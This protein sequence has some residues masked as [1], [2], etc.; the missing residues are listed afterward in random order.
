MTQFSPEQESRLAE[1][2]TK[3]PS[4][5]TLIPLEDV[6]ETIGQSS[7]LATQKEKLSR[8]L[9]NLAEEAPPPYE[10]KI[11]EVV[12]VAVEALHPDITFDQLS[13]SEQ[14]R[15][16]DDINNRIGITI[17]IKSI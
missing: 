11:Q 17:D 1:T 14:R 5:E 13:P 3:N 16:W 2:S 4:P 6:L 9:T 10:V 8:V 7:L 12:R 15:I